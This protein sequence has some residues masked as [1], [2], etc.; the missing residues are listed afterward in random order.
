MMSK[1]S[2]RLSVCLWGKLGVFVCEKA[3]NSKVENGLKFQI[4]LGR[5]GIQIGV[6]MVALDRHTPRL[7]EEDK[8]FSVPLLNR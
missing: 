6:A 3:F 7:S 8:S 2:T 4:D 5:K 1:H